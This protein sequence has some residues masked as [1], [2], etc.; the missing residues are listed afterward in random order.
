[1]TFGEILKLIRLDANLTQK[2]LGESLA[3]ARSYISEIES[4]D[5]IPSV[6]LVSKVSR[7][8]NITISVY[9]EEWNFSV[10]HPQGMEERILNVESGLSKI[11]KEWKNFSNIVDLI[12]RNVRR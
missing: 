10:K 8:Y 11:E 5:K 1:M 9:C 7:L 6:N 12:S 3:L 2:Q 4:S